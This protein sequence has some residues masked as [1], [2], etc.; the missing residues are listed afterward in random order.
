ML[1]KPKTILDN[2]TIPRVELD[3][4]NNTHFEEVEMVKQLGDIIVAYQESSTHSEEEI[5]TISES[6]HAWLEHTKAHFTRENELM[7]ETQFP[8]YEIH[9]EEHRIALYKMETVIKTW[10]INKD[11]E[12]VADYVFTLWPEWFNGHVNT[13]DMMTAKFAVMNGY[14]CE[15]N[16]EL[17]KAS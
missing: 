6:L 4:M 2:E 12:L 10:N 11:I 17:Q 16:A 5:S 9:S 14:P 1:K 7:R 13:M 8:A 3:F 15:N